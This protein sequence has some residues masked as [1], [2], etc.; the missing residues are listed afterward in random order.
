VTDSAIV[1]GLARASAAVS[2]LVEP[3]ITSA[4][5]QLANQPREGRFADPQ[6]IHDTAPAIDRLAA[7]TGRPVPWTPR[8][9]ESTG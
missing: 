4:R 6:P 7:V 1:D 9:A 5:A 8:T 2:D 3:A